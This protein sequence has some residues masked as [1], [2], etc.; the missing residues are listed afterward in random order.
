MWR[1]QRQPPTPT[2][3]PHTVLCFF[4]D[5][6]R[7]CCEDSLHHITPQSRRHR[8]WTHYM[9]VLT[10][11]RHIVRVFLLMEGVALQ[12]DLLL[13]FRSWPTLSFRRPTHRR[14][15]KRLVLGCP[16]RSEHLRQMFYVVTPH[17]ASKPMAPPP[18]NLPSGSNCKRY[19]LNA[20][21]VALL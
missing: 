9:T 7:V 3:T 19:E 20:C 12:V 4:R 11:Y 10:R 1:P 13:P 21:F 2:L 6:S 14:L 15:T 5:S 18:A 17:A 16:T 8:P